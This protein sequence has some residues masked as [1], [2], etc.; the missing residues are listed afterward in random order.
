MRVSAD[1]EKI[2][3]DNLKEE[4][5]WLECELELLGFKDKNTY[6]KN[7]ILI[8]NTVIDKVIDNIKS[9]ESE[10]VLNSLAITIN[11]IEQNYPHLFN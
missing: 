6:S 7:D 5:E 2:I 3:E 1:Y 11:R 8:G 9:N 10:D 4:L